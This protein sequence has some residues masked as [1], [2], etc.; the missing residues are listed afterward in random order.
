M[1]F[2]SYMQSTM[3]HDLKKYF[4]YD[5]HIEKRKM[6]CWNLVLLDGKNSFLGTKGES[7]ITQQSY[8]GIKIINGS[9]DGLLKTIV[10]FNQTEPPVYNATGITGN[11]DLELNAD[12]TDLAEIIKALNKIGLGMEK[13]EREMN[14]L[15]IK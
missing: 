8:T 5:I 1:G 7:S 13:S 10:G 4:E 6:P 12:M 15:V 9:L 3:Q 14:V 2:K 11:V